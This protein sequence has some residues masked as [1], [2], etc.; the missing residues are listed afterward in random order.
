MNGPGGVIRVAMEWHWGIKNM[1]KKSRS[2][3]TVRKH[4]EQQT[5]LSE[6]AEGEK[7]YK[8]ILKILSWIV[9]LSFTLIIILPNFVFPMV[10]LIVKIIFFIGFGTLLLFAIIEFFA[11]TIK[12]GLNGK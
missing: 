5:N 11:E 6:F 3:Q 10:D 4:H 9:G 12:K 8:F 7:R 2:A 1:G